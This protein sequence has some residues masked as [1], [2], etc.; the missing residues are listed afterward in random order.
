MAPSSTSSSHYQCT[1]PD[2]DRIVIA[3]NDTTAEL[4][5]FDGDEELGK[6][7]GAID[8]DFRPTN[9]ENEIFAAFKGFEA[10]IDSHD[11]GTVTLLVDKGLLRRA[12]TGPAK[13]R[14][15]SEHGGLFETVYSCTQL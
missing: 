11:P 8:P 1:A 15:T 2:K 5:K 6:A 4:T 3:V 9:P 12:A 13:L 10:L 7:E 14:E